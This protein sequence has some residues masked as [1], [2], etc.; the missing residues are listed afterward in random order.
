[1]EKLQN[2][3]NGELVSPAS[4]NYFDNYEP[5]TGKVYSLIPDSDIDDVNKATIAAKMISSI[6]FVCIF[7]G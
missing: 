3:I 5:A 7:F 1:M 4:G 6:I 2:Y